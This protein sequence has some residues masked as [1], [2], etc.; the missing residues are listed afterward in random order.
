MDT[1]WVVAMEG[2][3]EGQERANSYLLLTSL[4]RCARLG[5]M[6][7]SPIR[8]VHTNSGGENVG[9]TTSKNSSEHSELLEL[10]HSSTTLYGETTCGRTNK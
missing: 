5:P 8:T 2:S 6:A 9:R 3:G 4:A 10:T 7:A 1:L